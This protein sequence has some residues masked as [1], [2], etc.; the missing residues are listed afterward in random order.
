MHRG[1]TSPCARCH[2]ISLERFHVR[3]N[4]GYKEPSDGSVLPESYEGWTE[5]NLLAMGFRLH[6]KANQNKFVFCDTKRKSLLDIKLFFISYRGY[7]EISKVCSYLWSEA[8]V[9]D[10]VQFHFLDFQ[11]KTV[12]LPSALLKLDGN[13]IPDS[14]EL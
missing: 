14:L 11:E 10:V 1:T 4:N 2:S 5:L 13:R 8:R 3:Q 7:Q 12:F 6:E 9:M